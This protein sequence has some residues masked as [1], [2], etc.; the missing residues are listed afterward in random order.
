MFLH[1]IYVVFRELNAVGSRTITTIDLSEF[2][3]RVNLR[4]AL[5]KVVF[6]LDDTTLILGMS[7]H[8]GPSK[9]ENSD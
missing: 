7:F 8:T 9:T 2:S 1:G 6:V 5:D 4:E 3:R